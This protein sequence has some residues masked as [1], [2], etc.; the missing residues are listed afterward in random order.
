M[1]D[2]SEIVNNAVNIMVENIKKSLNGGLLSP[3]SLV[4]ILVNLMK[5][6]EGFPQL[7]GVQKKDVILKAFKNFVAQ[8]LSEGEKQN[9]EP[10]IDL[11]LPTLIDTLVSVDKREMQIKIKKLISKCCF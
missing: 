4:P 6:I 10:L 2:S 1:N 7:K 9:I 8:N 5:I 3:S 11:T